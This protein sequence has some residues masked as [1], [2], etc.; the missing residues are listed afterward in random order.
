MPYDTRK[1]NA[2]THPGVV[3]HPGTRRTSEEVAASKQKKADLKAAEEKRCSEAVRKAANIEDQMRKKDEKEKATRVTRTYKNKSAPTSRT[4]GS[5]ATSESEVAVVDAE[6]DDIRVAPKKRRLQEDSDESGAVK[7][8]ATARRAGANLAASD[9]DAFGLNDEEL[10]E[11]EDT[12]VPKKKKAKKN[13]KAA[14]P[15][16]REEI[17]AARTFIGPAV[18]VTET[19]NAKSKGAR[20]RGLRSHG[21]SGASIDLGSDAM[22]VDERSTGP[23]GSIALRTKAVPPTPFVGSRSK[24]APAVPSE[25]PESALESQPKPRPKPRPAYK[26]AQEAAA[27]AAAAAEAEREESE[28]AAAA[29]APRSKAKD[30]AP[31]TA[32]RSSQPAASQVALRKDGAAKKAAPKAAAAESTAAKATTARVTATKTKVAKAKVI[33]AENATVENAAATAPAAKA[34]AAKALT[35]KPAATK[36]STAKDPAT[37]MDAAAGELRAGAS[38]TKVAKV[39]AVKTKGTKGAAAL[40]VSK[41]SSTQGTKQDG[42]AT[43][44]AAVKTKAAVPKRMS[45]QKVGESDDDEGE[46]DRGDDEGCE[47][48]ASDSDGAGGLV[49]EGGIETDDESA[50]RD[51][52][53]SSPVKG[54][55][56]RLT[57]KNLVAIADVDVTT[58][59]P[60]RIKAKPQ[61]DKRA[62]AKKGKATS[63]SSGGGKGKGVK[64]PQQTSSANKTDYSDV[65]LIES[66]Q[67]SGPPLSKASSVNSSSS[68]D[69][70]KKAGSGKKWT[71]N[72]LPAG[73]QEDD[74]WSTRFVPTLL[75][76]Q[77]CRQDPWTWDPVSSVDIVQKIWNRVYGERLPHTVVM[78][79][80][81]HKVATQRIYDWRSGMA[82]GAVSI[83]EAIF[84]ASEATRYS[85]YITDGTEGQLEAMQKQED[86]R[87]SAEAARARF[88][89]KVYKDFQFVYRDPLGHDKPKEGLFHSPFILPILGT[90]LD[91][92]S[93]ALDVPDLFNSKEPLRT[94][95]PDR[96]VGAIALA[97]SAVERAISLWQKGR[98]KINEDGRTYCPKKLN[99]ST[100]KMSTASTDFRATTFVNKT[101][102]Y[103][104]TAMALTRKQMSALL[105][106]ASNSQT[107]AVEAIEQPQQQ[108]GGRRNLIEEGA[109]TDDWQ[110]SPQLGWG[111]EDRDGHDEP[112]NTDG[113]DNAMDIDSSDAPT[114]SFAS[115]LDVDS[116][117]EIMDDAEEEAYEGNGENGTAHD[118]EDDNENEDEDEDEDEDEGNG[119]SYAEA[120]DEAAADEEEE[121]EAEEEEVEEEEEE[122]EEEEGSEYDVEAIDSEGNS[123]E[124]FVLRDSEY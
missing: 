8:A 12:P 79:D 112:G 34:P 85:E 36:A 6:A 66:A 33:A 40:T 107:E 51:A 23:S 78:N 115:K 44:L 111:D 94:A 42:A 118:G 2:T 48:R 90:H 50:E 58:P 77:G 108:Q 88:C 83:M 61:D 37:K 55:V 67:P 81:V 56:A 41:A 14:R 17:E 71:T 73:A 121:G 16:L 100:G 32:V 110:S 116:D 124:E 28:S 91:Q 20:D 96:P 93:Q 11:L 120:E 76:Y 22:D 45:K 59:N 46:G 65:E 43:K 99:P 95:I 4:R 123:G 101:R 38:K 18:T 69:S 105:S 119:V 29:E 5:K 84:N 75:K 10:T 98:I 9:L 57:N 63:G 103:K 35:A 26:K 113:E 74:L 109:D 82:A 62:P 87:T 104:D 24:A 30:V 47:A 70:S 19:H 92:T 21:P 122:E 80:N 97:A 72:H 39:P 60:V 25:V 114:G 68:A 3:D 86:I 102:E 117:I 1:K 7:S 52:A 13:T 64:K 31:E 106:A 53:L 15:G 89:A 27:A 54:V 49:R